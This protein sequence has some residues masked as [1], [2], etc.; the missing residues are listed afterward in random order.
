MLYEPCCE[1]HKNATWKLSATNPED[2]ASELTAMVEDIWKR[3]G[4]PANINKEVAQAFAKELWGGVT[5]GYGKNLGG[6]IDYD[7][8]DFEMLKNLQNSVY[9]FSSAKN[10][11]QLKALTQSLIGDDGKLRSYSQ[12]KQAAFEINDQ[13]VNHWLKTEYDTAIASGQMAGKWADIEANKKTL[14]MLEFDAVMD[15]RTSAIC[16]SLNGVVKPVDDPFWSQWY[17][18]NHFGCRSTVKQRAGTRATPDDKIVYPDKVPEMFKVNLGKRGLAFPPDHPYF[19][20]LP[21]EVLKEAIKLQTKE[22]KA[23]AKQS[24]AGKSIQVPGVGKVEFSGNAIKEILNQPHIHK[25][26]KN[27]LLYGIDRA[28]KNGKYIESVP[29]SKGNQMIKAW[30]YVEV[31]VKGEKSYAVIREMASGE[32]I[33]YSIVDHLK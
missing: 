21:P 2:L 18:P 6:G 12:F 25:L 20:N 32:K 11:Q 9:Q 16:A 4:M 27:Q 3:K 10:Y 33:L 14:G 24:L 7:S 23:W 30:H 22:I 8:P 19:T 29:D 5:K 13:H 1:Q 28:L 31:K 26:E 17:P 15:N